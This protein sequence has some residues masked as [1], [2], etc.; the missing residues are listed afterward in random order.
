MARIIT[1]SAASAQARGGARGTVG[2]VVADIPVNPA[3]TTNFNPGALNVIR[4]TKIVIVNQDPAPGDFVPAGTQVTVTV[5]EKG[6]IPPRS[7]SVI[8]QAVVDKYPTISALEEDL[9]KA[10]D[11]V[12]LGAKNALNKGVPFNQLSEADKSAVSAYVANRG[13]AGATPANAAKSAS[14]IAFLFQL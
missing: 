7:F 14:D 1:K 2:T 12:A 13:L 10:N 6:L 8:S 3:F 9:S 4:P 5:V 11:P